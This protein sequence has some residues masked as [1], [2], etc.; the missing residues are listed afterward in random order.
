MK[1]IVL[2]G[3]GGH[4]HSV[5]DVIESKKDYKI[6]GILDTNEN[7]GKSILNYK[8]IGTDDDI[9]QFTKIYNNFVITIGQ[10]KNSQIRQTIYK[11]VKSVGGSLPV[12]IA[13]S[14]QVS[15]YSKIEEGT[16]IH[17]NAFV[18]TNAKIGKMGIINT[19]SIIEHDSVISDFCH[20]STNATINGDSIINSYTFIGSGAVVNNSI[21]IGRD[22]IIASGSLIRNNI[23]DNSLILE[24]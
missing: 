7:I 10:I 2:I 23:H 21:V 17:H 24:N 12:I 1:D 14:A 8:V 15:K 13:K 11:K 3:G 19:G 20:I 6:I 22:V 5:I 16:V 18:N 9:P 4:C